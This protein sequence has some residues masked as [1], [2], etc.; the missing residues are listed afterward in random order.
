MFIRLATDIKFTML[1]RKDC[2]CWSSFKAKEL[3][4]GDSH[5][6]C[7]TSAAAAADS[8]VS[9]EIGNFQIFY[10]QQSAIAACFK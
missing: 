4:K 8:C 2:K 7:L 6:E 5:E 3:K 1:T 10:T 9:T